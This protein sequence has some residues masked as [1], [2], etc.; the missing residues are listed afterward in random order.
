MER[1]AGCEV[2]QDIMHLF[3][4]CSSHSI[5]L[6]SIEETL[7]TKCQFHKPLIKAFV[8][9]WSDH[10]DPP[11]AGWNDLCIRYRPP[12]VRA[13]ECVYLTA[14]PAVGRELHWPLLLVNKCTPTVPQHPGTGRVLDKDWA[15]LSL[16]KRWKD[17][18]LSLHG[19]KCE[20][21][22]RIWHTRPAWLIDVD[23]RC[24][25]PGSVDGPFVALSYMYGRHHEAFRIDE[26]ILQRLQEPRCFDS[27]DMVSTQLLSPI[28]RHAMSLTATI[29][30]R[31]LWA[32]AICITYNDDTEQLRQMGAIYANAILTIIATDGD[33]QDGL[34]GIAKV[35]NLRRGMVD[36]PIFPLGGDEQIIVR[37]PGLG[38]PTYAK[39][40]HTRGW[41]YQEERVS[42]RKIIFNN[43]RLHWECQCAVSHE[44]MVLGARTD[45][46]TEPF[47]KAMVD[48]LPDL[49]AL[50]ALINGYNTRNLRYEEDALP[51]ISGVL[52]VVS[53]SFTG[54]FLYGIPEM[55][56]DRGLGWRGL[57]QDNIDL[58]RR[59][60]S[61]KLRNSNFPESGLPSWSWVGWGGRVLINFY[62][63]EAL[64][65]FYPYPTHERFSET[66]PTTEWFTSD[67]LDTPQG[68]RRRIRSTWFENRDGYKDFSRPLPP[69]WTRHDRPKTINDSRL[70]PDGCDKFFFTHEQ[71]LRMW[72][73]P[74]PVNKVDESIPPFVP[75]Q[76]RYLFCET[77]RAHLWSHQ[78]GA[79]DD[80]L[81]ASLEN[82]ARM[83]I[84]E[85]YL[86]SY[87]DYARLP[88]RTRGIHQPGMPV[89]VVAIH[90]S[91]VYSKLPMDNRKVHLFP[92]PT[93][94]TYTVLWVEWQDGVA[95]RR[96]SGEVNGDEWER[97]DLEPISLVLG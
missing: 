77:K 85:L 40:Y 56:F 9:F 46:K 12:T 2:C 36:Q 38:T 63:E 1:F 25:V 58:R 6:G 81:I 22:L 10:S 7:A 17:A 4:K 64:Q 74:F 75:A 39:P 19:T 62:R 55:F 70:Y 73:Y 18:C 57:L 48:G 87:E 76:S 27:I 45:E 21:P 51:A 50:E 61:R 43:Y 93:C 23:Q 11:P 31:Y 89:E 24:L 8:E 79:E 35:S 3:T 49:N 5:R 83:L 41:T 97:L 80:F 91:R 20:N 78:V 95:Y 71:S 30:E 60:P 84:G 72:L 67:S 42:P 82:D 66:I 94:H 28:I 26:E 14:F 68:K 34:L 32:D 53:R 29:G 52:S 54:G 15:D 88:K 59:K 86:H 16:L 13:G 96:A 33:S 69:G 47:L 65:P 90:K 92:S 37:S 44:D